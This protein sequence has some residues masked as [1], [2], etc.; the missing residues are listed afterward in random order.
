MKYVPKF[1]HLF[2]ILFR[3][4]DP[5]AAEELWLEGTW[6]HDNEDDEGA[7]L[8]FRHACLLDR[9]FAGAYYNFAALTEKHRGNSSETRK[10]WEEYLQIAE[11][12]SRQ[13]AETIARVR[14]HVQELRQEAEANK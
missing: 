3:R 5:E 11:K 14:E 8:A 1:K 12:D 6:L 10:A 7:L 9:N 4:Q 2:K 13:K